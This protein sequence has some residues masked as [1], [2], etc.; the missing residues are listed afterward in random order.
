MEEEED[1]QR[2]DPLLRVTV[3][4][5]TDWY[6]N[7]AFPIVVRYQSLRWVLEKPFQEFHELHRQLQLP[8]ETTDQLPLL[9]LRPSINSSSS[10]LDRCRNELQL[11][12]DAL[13]SV[14][15]SLHQNNEC[16]RA[17]CDMMVIVDSTPQVASS[18]SVV[19]TP[20]FELLAKIF[21]FLSDGEL[22]RIVPSVCRYWRRV[23][24][25]DVLWRHR[26]IKRFHLVQNHPLVFE[27]WKQQYEYCL[28]NPQYVVAT[29]DEDT[30]TLMKR[31]QSPLELRRKTFEK[32]LRSERKYLDYLITIVEV[33]SN[34]LRHQMD[35][36]EHRRLFDKIE[37]FAH[38]HRELLTHFEQDLI[39][40]NSTTDYQWSGIAKTF[41]DLRMYHIC[42][43]IYIHDS[44]FQ[45]QTYNQCMQ[46]AKFRCFLE[47]CH[48]NPRCSGLTLALLLKKPIKR[49]LK[50]LFYLRELEK[51][52]P[53]DHPDYKDLVRQ[54]TIYE[55]QEEDMHRI[56]EPP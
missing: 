45:Q 17:F 33:F 25:V 49:N 40:F 48:S 24:E 10:E 56:M 2:G 30:S 12:F 11:Y 55:V 34:P 13:L 23:S 8:I 27:T 6:S 5:P 36:V 39:A 3:K 54:R 43:S 35:A 9:P 47:E 51:H 38:L 41:S 32:L 52:T 28:T 29:M 21:D 19:A 14:E 46:N 22:G 44:K 1:Q 4:H 53:K 18:S 20:P 31:V 37:I 26:T 50:Y 15:P 42:Y 16:F 7:E